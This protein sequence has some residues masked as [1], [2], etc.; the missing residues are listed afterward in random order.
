M[1]QSVTRQ[2]PRFVPT[3][4]DVV[5]DDQALN[6]TPNLSRD[7]ELFAGEASAQSALPPATQDT[8]MSSPP[9][10]QAE[11]AHEAWVLAAQSIQARVMERVEES[12]EERLRYALAEV[13]QLHTQSLYQALRA[14]IEQVVHA[15]VHEALA[16][17][18]AQ[19]RKPTDG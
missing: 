1:S 6:S 13:V 11:D 17:E 2:P 12:L 14:D 3:L 16:Q 9:G 8:E 19:I 7:A 10:K 18:L 5:P 15:A 4:T